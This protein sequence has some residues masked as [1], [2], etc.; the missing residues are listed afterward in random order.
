MKWR[1]AWRDPEG[2]RWT[3]AGA[4]REDAARPVA[5]V[6][7]VL[8]LPAPQGRDP[9]E[10]LDVHSAAASG[11]RDRATWASA[12]QR[13]ASWNSPI[14][15]WR[16]PRKTPSW[17]RLYPPCRGPAIDRGQLLPQLSDPRWPRALVRSPDLLERLRVGDRSRE[18]GGEPYA[19]I[20]G[21]VLGVKRD[22][23]R[24]RRSR[25]RSR[26]D[27]ARARGGPSRRDCD[28]PRRPGR[29]RRPHGHT[30]RCSHDPHHQEQ[31]PD[32]PGYRPTNRGG[33]CWS[34]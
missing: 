28:R 3:A 5:A 14:D 32:R 21:P 33:G 15:M 4:E 8:R 12:K 23:W 26:L 16:V 18:P 30:N 27:L 17:S 31:E 1:I 2:C 9:A 11:S 13:S 34:R 29:I 22:P 19:A 10:R 20:L 25:R 24:G 6:D 7:A